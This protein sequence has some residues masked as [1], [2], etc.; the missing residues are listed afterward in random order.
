MSVRYGNKVAPLVSRKSAFFK[1]NR[2][3]SSRIKKPSVAVEAVSNAWV[4]PTDWLTMPTI[5]SSEQKIAM[6]MPV[7]PQGSNF[8][9]FTVAGAY[10]VDWGD[11]VIENVATG[12]KAQHEYSYA[13][14]D[15]NPTVTSGGYKMAIVVVTPQAGQNITSVNF[16]QKY[17]LTGST[18]PNSSPILEII[19]SCPNMTSFSLGTISPLTFCKNLINFSGVNMGLLTSLSY[20]FYNLIS[21][22]NISFDNTCV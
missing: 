21:L 6:L 8:L 1:K 18:F 12:V 4:R 16:N 2:F 3:D 10:T 9:A 5:T 19:L 15:L 17:A 13:D 7:Y 14:A 22:K 20:A 11:G